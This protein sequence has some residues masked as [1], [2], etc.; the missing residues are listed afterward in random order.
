VIEG[1]EEE[2]QHVILAL[3]YQ[4]AVFEHGIGH[5][6]EMN[7]IGMVHVI[8]LV[9][10]VV[11]HVGMLSHLLDVLAVGINTFL[12]FLFCHDIGGSNG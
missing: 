10:A 7:A 4:V 3:A 6:V 9:H 1:A 11:K 5:H 8:A 2:W 12:K